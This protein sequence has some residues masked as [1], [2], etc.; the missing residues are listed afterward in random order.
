MDTGSVVDLAVVSSGVVEAI[1]GGEVVGV[2]RHLNRT[3]NPVLLIPR[4][5]LE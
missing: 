2:A 1:V 4:R 3:A 5:P